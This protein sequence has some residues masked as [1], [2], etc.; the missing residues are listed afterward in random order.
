MR[1]FWSLPPTGRMPWII[2]EVKHHGY[3]KRQ[4]PFCA[5]LPSLLFTCRLLFLISQWQIQGRGGGPGLPPLFFDQN[6]AQR[7][8]TL[9][10]LRDACHELLEKLSIT[11]TSNG[12]R[13]FVPRYQ[14][15]SLLVVYCSL[16]LS[17]RS[18]GGEGGL[19]SRPYFLTKMRPKGPKP[20]FWDQPLPPFLI[21]ESGWPGPPF[22]E[23]LDPPLFLHLN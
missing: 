15:F 20:F 6:E 11:V 17:G 7:A 2:R 13:H 21:S 1:M 16:F 14:V 10:L 4:T 23:G 18:R 9:C 12:K 3:V 19:A 22:S 8:K 5:T